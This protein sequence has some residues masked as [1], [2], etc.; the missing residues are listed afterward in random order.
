MGFRST[1]TG[2]S[3]ST[4][5]PRRPALRL[6]LLRRQPRPRRSSR[7][8][9]ALRRRRRLRSKRVSKDPRQL[10]RLTPR[11]RRRRLSPRQRPHPRSLRPLQAPWLVEQPRRRRSF[12][13]SS[14]RRT[15]DPLRRLRGSW[16]E[17]PVRWSFSRGHSRAGAGGCLGSATDPRGVSPARAVRARHEA[18]GSAWRCGP[19]EFDD[20]CVGSR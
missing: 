7:G 14:M 20:A 11:R 19:V 9:P 2:A 3:S 8:L 1:W 10:R 16:V 15:H 6:P 13:L 12:Q 18:D 4:Q 5:P 17:S